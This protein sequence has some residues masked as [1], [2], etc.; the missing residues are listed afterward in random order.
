MGGPRG[1]HLRRRR[2]SRYA[3][4]GRGAR[5]ASNGHVSM[6]ALNMPTVV[7]FD[8]RMYVCMRARVCVCESDR[9][10]RPVG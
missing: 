3:S 7:D 9:D 4:P 1:R 8:V 5:R 10:G 2:V 6:R